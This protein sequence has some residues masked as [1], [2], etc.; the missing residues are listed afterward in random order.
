MDILL[1]VLGLIFIV[2]GIIGCIV[3]VLPGVML[4]YAGL[5]CAYFCS[6]SSIST[7][8]LIILLALTLIA[9]LIDYIMPVYL[10]KL[11]GGSKAG[12]RGA[13]VGVIVGLIFGG[14][15]GAI[16]G[17]LFGAMIGEYLHDGRDLSRVFKVGLGTFV[18]F[19][20][21]TGLKLILSGVML[22]KVLTDVWPVIKGIFQ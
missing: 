20:V 8:Y 1:V 5:V 11:S 13:A 16:L 18:A 7:T 2:V 4:A 10:A 12:E 3:P 6:W 17:P 9:S 22:V 19:I 14:V 21:G 15:V